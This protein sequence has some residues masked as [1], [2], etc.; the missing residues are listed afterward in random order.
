MNPDQVSKK[1][2]CL[3]QFIPKTDVAK[4]NLC[5]EFSQFSMIGWSYDQEKSN[6]DPV[7]DKPKPPTMDEINAAFD[8][9]AEPIP[10]QLDE[11]LSQPMVPDNFS[12][13]EEE[14]VAPEA[15][16]EDVDGVRRPRIQTVESMRP[17]GSQNLEYAWKTNYENDIWAGPAYWKIKSIQHK[18]MSF[19]QHSNSIFFLIFFFEL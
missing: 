5:E 19:Y 11:S 1:I 6:Q 15:Q 12:S 10:M 8:M 7:N 3:S 2:K 9:E 18:S 14:V 16:K 4:L 17:G 13:D